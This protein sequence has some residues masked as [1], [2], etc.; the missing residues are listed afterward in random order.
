MVLSLLICVVLTK[1]INYFFV[2]YL[3]INVFDMFLPKHFDYLK[4]FPIPQMA[5]IPELRLS[6]AYRRDGSPLLQEL[7]SYL[8]ES[9]L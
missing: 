2:C 9:G 4:L 6:V 7:A 8:Q 3:V 5:G 1:V